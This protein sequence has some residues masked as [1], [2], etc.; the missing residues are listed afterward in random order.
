[1]SSKSDIP[2][3]PKPDGTEVPEH[4]RLMYETLFVADIAQ[5]AFLTALQRAVSLGVLDPEKHMKLLKGFSDYPNG[6]KK[7]EE[8]LAFLFE[9]T[10]IR[11]TQNSSKC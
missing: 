8:D 10:L 7:L 5:R 9:Q 6:A 4:V 3:V 1:M 2:S 11:F